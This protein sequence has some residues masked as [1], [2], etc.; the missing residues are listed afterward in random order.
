LQCPPDLRLTGHSDR[1]RAQHGATPREP[2]GRR[3]GRGA[4]HLKRERRQSH[5]IDARD[6]NA[7]AGR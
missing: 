3:G 5:A 7:P 4:D 6:R 2:G 1:A